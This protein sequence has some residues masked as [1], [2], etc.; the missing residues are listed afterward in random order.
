M[1]NWKQKI[2]AG[3]TTAAMLSTV[4]AVSAF[5]DTSVSGNGAF[6]D[7]LANTNTSSNTRV[8]QS[9][10]TNVNND[11]TTVANTGGVSASF[12]TGGS[13]DVRTGDA[14]AS[15]TVDTE[16]GTNVASLSG[17]NS[18]SG[19][20]NV[21]L[22][23][24]G[25]FSDN[26]VRV[27][28]TNST[29]AQ[30][31]NNTSVNNDIQ[32]VANTGGVSANFNTGTDV[33]VQTGDANANTQVTTQGGTNLL[34]LN[35]GGSGGGSGTNVQVSGNGAF[36]DNNVLADTNNRTNVR[37]TN[38]T[39]VMNDILNAANTGGVSG[40][41]NTGADVSVRTGDADATT[42]VFT[43]GNSNMLDLSGCNSCS[44]STDIWLNGNGA[45]S[46]SFVRVNNRNNVN[47]F[48]NNNSHVNNDIDNLANT[49]GVNGS[50]NTSFFPLL[51]NL[52]FNQ[53]F[54]ASTNHLRN[55]MIFPAMFTNSSNFFN[56]SCCS[57]SSG[58]VGFNNFNNNSNRLFGLSL[59]GALGGN[60]GGNNSFMTGNANSNTS[61]NTSGSF[62][63]AD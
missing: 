49:G 21:D 12:N 47:V 24:N 26:N 17:C 40:S 55:K 16:G 31:T 57:F 11:L 54:F 53:P 41:F 48:Q 42:D 8:T 60:T 33:T 32:N 28:N 18:C 59:F 25:A 29:T 46:Q 44:N 36:S 19:S 63:A 37:Q 5:A 39:N 30:Q 10:N 34:D 1:L 51:N 14:S 50:G 56:N 35:N 20:N 3:I 4:L 6:S 27:R 7:N 2:G 13:V 61:V 58:Q 23:G 45:F 43:G 52:R 22:S 38:R 15:T 9:N 62:N